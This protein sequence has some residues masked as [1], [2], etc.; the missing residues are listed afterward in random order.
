MIK[1]YKKLSE[2][3]KRKI[4]EANSKKVRSPELRK[5]ISDTLKRKGIKPKQIYKEV[6]EKHWRWKGGSRGI[7]KQ[8]C[9]RNN[10]D[11]TTC[12]IC[13]DKGRMVVHHVDGNF[14]NNNPFNLAV[15]CYFC[16]NSIHNTGINTRFK[17]G[18]DVPNKWRAKISIA[19]KH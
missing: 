4:G 11:L 12:R 18:H 19:N 5:R 3:H 9:K 17:Q 13:K 8:I 1:K 14:R 2:E 10:I 6:G 7:M 15:L 16:H